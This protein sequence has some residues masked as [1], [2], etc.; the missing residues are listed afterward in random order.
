MF[1]GIIAERYCSYTDLRDELDL[2]DAKILNN[3][4]I[5]SRTNEHR[6]TKAAKKHG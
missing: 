1:S 5:A 2:M 6:A 4:L 3:I